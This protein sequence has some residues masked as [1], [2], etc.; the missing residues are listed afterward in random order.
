MCAA[1]CWIAGALVGFSIQLVPGG[2]LGGAG[3]TVE[4]GGLP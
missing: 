2:R 3:A 1:L 4:N